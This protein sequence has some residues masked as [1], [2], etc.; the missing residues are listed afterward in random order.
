MNWGRDRHLWEGVIAGA[1]MVLSWVL[2]AGSAVAQLA[3]VAGLL[4]AVVCG[5]WL[6]RRRLLQ[7]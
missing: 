6:A 5:A 1:V 3:G 7:R 4:L 2:Y